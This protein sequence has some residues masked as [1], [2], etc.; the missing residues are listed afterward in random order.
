MLRKPLAVLYYTITNAVDYPRTGTSAQVIGDPNMDLF[1][2]PISDW[3]ALKKM[4]GSGLDL[5]PVDEFS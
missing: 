3:S 5:K 1:G 2:T 4:D